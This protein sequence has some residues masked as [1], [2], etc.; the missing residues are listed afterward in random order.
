MRRTGAFLPGMGL[1]Q[2]AMRLAVCA[3][4]MMAASVGYCAALDAQ[5]PQLAMLDRLHR[6]A[7][8]VRPR[9]DEEAN[10]RVCLATG[11]ELIQLKHARLACNRVV[12]DDA[13]QAVTVQY[14]CTGNGYGRTHIRM[15]SDRL[16]QIDTQGIERGLP[17][18]F[19]AEA[20]WVG[21]CP[22]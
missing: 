3:M 2:A 16:V 6:G 8:E 17:F 13:A 10:S 15:E 21:S 11:R 20:R 5:A 1:G 9:G 19:G 7:W 4:A 22:R 18:A 14:S 12:V